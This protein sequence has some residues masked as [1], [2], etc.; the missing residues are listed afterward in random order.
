MRKL[1][2]LFAAAALFM[3]AGVQA[4]K[5]VTSQ[6]ITNATLSNGT[7][8]W[9]VSNFNAPQR[10]NNTVGYASE[11]YAGW[12]NLG[13]KSYSLTQKITLP[14]GN[15]T[16][17]NYSFF[18]Q[19]LTYNTEP[20]KSLAFLKANDSQVAIKTLGSITAGGYANTQAEGANAFDSKMY[21]NT[22]DFTVEADGTELEIGLVGTFDL[23]QSWCIAGMFELIDNDQLATMDSPFDVTGYLANPGFEYRNAGG[24]TLENTG[25]LSNDYIFHAQSNNA[26]AL[27]TGGFYGEA[28]QASGSLS[29]R[30][31]Y[32]ELSGLPNGY[33]KLSANVSYG[34]SG[35]FIYLNDKKTDV[36]ANNAT[37]YTVGCVIDDG[38]LTVGLGLEN[39][40]S[41]YLAFDGFSLQFCGD[42]AAALTTLAGQ[43]TSYKGKIP[44]AA[45][46]NLKTAV[47]EKNQSYSDV[48]ELLAAIQDIQNLYGNA[49]LLVEPYT[50]A[51]AL[52][53]QATTLAAG[54]PNLDT[55]IS[56][57]SQ[58]LEAFTTK[59][60]IDALNTNLT[61]ANAVLKTWVDLKAKANVLVAVANNNA[62]ANSTLAGVI[63]EQDN[64]VKSVTAADEVNLAKVTT[65]ITTLKA[66][67]TTYVSE[68]N[69]VGD[70]AKFDC[71]FLMTNPDL[72][73]LTT[74]QK[75]DG[76]AS[77]ET[78]GNSQVMTNASKTN[79]TKSYFYEYWSETAKASGKFALYNTVYL[80]A[81][82]YSMSCYAFAEDQNT[83]STVDGVY[84]Y[85]ND[86]QGS[87]VTATVLTEQALSFVNNTEQ[88]VKIGLKTLTGNTRNWMG[89]GYVELYKV[90]AQTY[91][92]SEDAGWDNTQSG[93]GDVTLTR[94]IKS[95]GVN[96]L[97]LPF[98]MTQAE[99]EATFGGGSKVYVVSSYA[100]DNISF[101]QYDGI[102]A[103]KP[104]LLV[105]NVAGS[106]YNIEGRTIVAG[107]P[108]ANGT[109]VSMKGNYAATFSAPMGS[110]IFS[111]NKIYLVDSDVSLKA[112]R[113]YITVSD[114]STARALT[115][116]LG[117][118]TTGVITL[119]GG[120]LKMEKGAIYD[121]SGRRVLNPAKGIYLINGKKVVK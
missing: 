35:A 40:T 88:N 105:T 76:W 18:R 98:S 57:T 62:L 22:L 90:P 102:S 13:V 120:E 110:Y 82:T 112:T 65:A 9:T 20:E 69:P 1:K 70:G 113:A 111:N 16:L 67:M 43:V 49:D 33:Y 25:D 119:E 95:D 92:V 44:T 4:Q 115:F 101:V 27:K 91:A 58:A 55:F 121:L 19:G 56:T 99:V 60:Q 26:F 41:N 3:C 52:L 71:T 109:G 10:G 14:K 89:I 83:S 80:P 97:V 48:D 75:A 118:E 32:Q 103:N 23:K 94:T 34:G 47:D 8:G 87:C 106:S 12:D 108:E 114:P 36:E 24:W 64:Q 81:G 66:A 104:C 46:N 5:D 107:D 37:K 78:D 61:K 77:E 29:D 74:W 38:K 17:V 68:A 100:D 59:A 42:V 84:F 21:R 30:K 96:T 45:Y 86:T 85:A 63:T 79:G 117:D 51:K 31:M 6:Y 15:Y 7:T 116:N 28:W 93:A 53:D 73:G 2:L 50:Q 72:T 11:A 54:Y 39:G